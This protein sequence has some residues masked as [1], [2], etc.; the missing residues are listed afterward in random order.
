MEGCGPGRM[1]INNVGH[2]FIDNGLLHFMYVCRR[3][4]EEV[5]DKARARICNR[6]LG[7]SD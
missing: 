5:L 7:Q 1:C 4:V 6:L 2:D 3:D